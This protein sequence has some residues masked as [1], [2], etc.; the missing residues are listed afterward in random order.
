MA[1]RVRVVA[2]AVTMALG[3]GP[4][5]E[6][7]RACG[8]KFLVAG[9][10]TRYQRPRGARA[11]T[12]LIYADAASLATV[13]ALKSERLESALR[14]EGHRATLV[15][16]GADLRAILAGGRFDVV[17]TAASAA[18]GV[19]RLVGAAPDA[20]VVVALDA[21]PRGRSLAEAIDRAVAQR[22]RSLRKAM[23]HS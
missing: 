23:S 2:L 17:L 9:R 5:A 14:R 6:T 10:G 11:A 8:E 12:V 3:V 21:Q 18:P 16:T 15:E 1:N 20:A 22:D 7:V 4:A 13:E 19:A